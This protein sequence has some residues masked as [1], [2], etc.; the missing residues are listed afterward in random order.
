MTALVVDVARQFAA[1][2][3]H[4]TKAGYWK[5]LTATGIVFGGPCILLGFMVN[6]TNVGTLQL[7]DN[8]TTNTNPTGGIITPAAGQFIAYPAILLAGLY[9]VI[10][11]TALDVTFFT[12]R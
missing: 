3:T 5:N 6:S 9:A 1:H 10:A 11:G 7:F 8:A 4:A 12:Q 2:T